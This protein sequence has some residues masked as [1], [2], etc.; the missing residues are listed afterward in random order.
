[1]ELDDAVHV[2]LLTL[3]ESFEGEMTGTYSFTHSFT[4]LLTRSFRV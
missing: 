4:Y 2:A 1:M 3:R